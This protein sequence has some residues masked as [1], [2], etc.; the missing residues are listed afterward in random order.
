MRAKQH[1]RRFIRRNQRRARVL[2]RSLLLHALVLALVGL[3]LLARMSESSDVQL[4]AAEHAAALAQLDPP[5][6]PPALPY[7]ARGSAVPAARA[8]VPLSGAQAPAAARLELA[9][10]S[11]RLAA[12]VERRWAA[13]GVARSAPPE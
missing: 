10:P 12:P 13:A 7:L 11:A 6:S 4:A 2:V 8:D 9:A 5:A 1:F 3:G